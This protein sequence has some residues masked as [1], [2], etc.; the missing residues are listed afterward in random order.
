MKSVAAIAAVLVAVAVLLMVPVS[1]TDAVYSN[2]SGE[3]VI[4]TSASEDYTITYNNTDYSSYADV[5]ISVS[6]SAKLVDSDG[7]TVSSG[8]SPSSGSIDNGGSAT[9]TVKAPSNA[10]RYQLVVEYTADVSYTDSEGE[11]V[12]VDEDDLKLESTKDIRVVTPVTLS[13]SLTNDSNV[14]LSSYG[15]YFA[16]LENGSWVTLDDSYKTVDLAKAGTA[17]VSYDWV[18]DPSDGKYTFKVIPADSG[19]LITISGLDE[20]H[21]FYIG[22][23]DYSLWIWIL[24]LF[25]IILIVVMVWV[26]RKPVKNYGKPKSRR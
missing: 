13:V 18:A 16:M 11:T 7:D 5:S 22:D 12:E 15:V 19:N 14:D 2:I 17:T 26:Y 6:Y 23:N 3:D 10:G 20:E 9:L 8:V 21:S 4:A 25:V 24:V 1:E